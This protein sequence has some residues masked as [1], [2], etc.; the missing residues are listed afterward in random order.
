[1][2]LVTC[3][4]KSASAR[5]ASTASQTTLVE[6]VVRSRQAALRVAAASF[7]PCAGAW[8]SAHWHRRSDCN[9][10]GG[11][12]QHDAVLLP[13][14][15]AWPCAA[16][17]AGAQCR[18]AHAMSPACTEAAR[19]TRVNSSVDPRRQPQHSRRQA[20]HCA[21][22]FWSTQGL[23]LSIPSKCRPVAVYMTISTYTF[24]GQLAC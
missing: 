13:E 4:T 15:S 21:T 2:R 7:G 11:R 17:S 16:M 19:A 3:E 8:S 18:A 20:G 24:E 5:P 9:V 23:W 14:L 1:M 12:Q 6:P 22:R 10:P